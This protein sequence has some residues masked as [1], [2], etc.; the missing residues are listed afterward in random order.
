MPLIVFAALLAL[1]V[2]ANLAYPLYQ[3]L[4]TGAF[5]WLNM[6]TQHTVAV[7]RTPE[8]QVSCLILVTAVW[9]AL[10]LRSAWPVILAT[11]VMYTFVAVPAGFV[12][13]AWEVRRW[14]GDRPGRTAGP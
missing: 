3:A 2:V 6:V 5:A 12:A 7:V 11:P 10:R 1:L 8:P 9:L 14:W 4:H 13:G